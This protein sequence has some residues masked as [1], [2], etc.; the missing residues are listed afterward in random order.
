MTDMP[1]HP[2]LTHPR[3]GDPLRAL[4]RTRS[5]RLVWPQMGAAPDDP[6]DPADPPADPPK[7][8]APPAG[9]PPKDD[10]KP[11]GP[12]GE[13]ALAAERAKVK[14]QE[15]ELAKYRKA[16]KDKADADKTESEKRAAAEERATAAELKATKLEVAAEKGLTVAQAKRLVGSTREELQ[17]DADEILR[18]FPVTPGKAPAPKPD[19]SQGPKGPSTTRP[20]S[21]GAAVS[22][23]MKPKT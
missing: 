17:A 4:Y 12:G 2:H 20:T 18:D 10:D 8:D 9:D 3:T 11:L 21:L 1:F 19:L 7:D 22:G 15:K 16:E 23:A 13:K 6:A 14:E 5:G